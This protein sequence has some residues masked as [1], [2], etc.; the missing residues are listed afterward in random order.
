MADRQSD[1]ASHDPAEARRGAARQMSP[2]QA[3]RLAPWVALVLF[4]LLA[5]LGGVLPLRTYI[6]HHWPGVPMQQAT[7]TSVQVRPSG[8]EIIAVRAPDGSD[9]AFTFRSHWGSL[10]KGDHLAVYRKAGAWH[11]RDSQ[12][13]PVWAPVALLLGLAGVVGS[14]IALVRRL[15]R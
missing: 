1:T 4:G 6:T 5:V 15:R 12:G 2:E 13:L 9:Q 7:V 11:A 8:R 14:V 3:Q 10:S